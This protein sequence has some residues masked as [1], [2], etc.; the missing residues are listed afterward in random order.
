M[1]YKLLRGAILLAKRTAFVHCTGQLD[2]PAAISET[3]LTAIDNS[4]GNLSITAPLL[5]N[6]PVQWLM[7]A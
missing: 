6:T 5:P 2:F 1:W 3:D 4:Y 7:T